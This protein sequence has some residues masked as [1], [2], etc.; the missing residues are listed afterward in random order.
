MIVLKIEYDTYKIKKQNLMRQFMW[1]GCWIACKLWLGS[2]LSDGLYFI[3]L[4]VEVQQINLSVWR[5]L[6]LL[7]VHSVKSHIT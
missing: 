4:S 3:S 6:T 5:Q 2:Q 1:L 7:L